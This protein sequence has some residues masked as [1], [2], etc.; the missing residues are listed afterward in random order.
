MKTSLFYLAAL[1]IVFSGCDKIKDATTKDISTQLKTDIPVVVVASGKKSVNQ[2]AEVNAIAFSETKELTLASNADIEPYLNK[3]ESINLY[4]LVVTVTGLGAE[5]FISS[6]SLDVA[7]VGNIFT[8][9]NITAGN[10]TFTPVIAESTLANVAAKLESD[11]KIT[12]TLSGLASGPMVFT[13][14]LNFNATL[15]VSLV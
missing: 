15:T 10:N 7:G 6:M 12:L 13:V 3:I 9:T 11:R 8:Q 4:S 5:Q 14:N 2:T 1:I